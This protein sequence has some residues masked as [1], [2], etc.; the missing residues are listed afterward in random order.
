MLSQPS[1]L[2]VVIRSSSMATRTAPRYLRPSSQNVSTPAVVAS[3]RRRR[4]TPTNVTFSHEFARCLLAIQSSSNSRIYDVYVVPRIV[5]NTLKS[6][7]CC[8]SKGD[9][10]MHSML[11]PLYTFWVGNYSSSFHVVSSDDTM[12]RPI[13]ILT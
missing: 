13:Q 1:L 12:T 2:H 8:R 10:V 7:K 3:H 11:E 6:V 9:I 5:L 4:A